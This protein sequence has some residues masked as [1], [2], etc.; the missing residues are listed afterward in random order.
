MST[1]LPFYDRLLDQARRYQGLGLNHRAATLLEQLADFRELPGDVVEEAQHRLAQ[2]AAEAERYPRS[3]RHLAA[4]I[5]H[6]PTSAEYRSE[7]G[8]AVERDP[9]CAPDEALDC[10]AQATQFDP[11]NPRYL[12]EYGSLAIRLGEYE[13][14]LNLLRQARDAAPNDMDVLESLVTGLVDAGESD[15]ARRVLRDESFRQSGNRRF[16]ARYRSLRFRVT[17]GEQ[18]APAPIE[19]PHVLPMRR[20]AE[21]HETEDGRLVRHD[22]AEGRAGPRRQT[23]DV[24]RNERTQRE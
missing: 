22:A 2:L 12:C 6:R 24:S 7:M 19:E 11:E 17:H 1:T 13:S 14:G 16:Q 20:S 4:A 9:A 21:F 8:Q 18:H 5:A 23:P 15:E 10:Y 3:R